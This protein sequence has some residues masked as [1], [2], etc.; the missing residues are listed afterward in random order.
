MRFDVNLTWDCAIVFV[1]I[2]KPARLHPH[3]DFHSA[4]EDL[5]WQT[6]FEIYTC[7]KRL[8]NRSGAATANITARFSESLGTECEETVRVHMYIRVLWL[9]S[10]S[11]GARRLHWGMCLKTTLKCT[12]TIQSVSGLVHQ[13]FVVLLPFFSCSLSVW[14]RTKCEGKV[15]WMQDSRGI[16]F[17]PT[18]L[19]EHVH[20]RKTWMQH[21][22][23]HILYTSGSQSCQLVAP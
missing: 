12:L 10:F 23:Y 1:S 13:C 14:D 21:V 9:S 16:A 11:G 20:Y 18:V 22:W 5:L 4:Y 8:K 7:L 19:Y 6:L 3:L 2:R 17:M 15:G